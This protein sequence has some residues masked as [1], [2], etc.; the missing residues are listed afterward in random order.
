M[1]LKTAIK[2]YKGFHWGLDPDVVDVIETPGRWPDVLVALGELEA[3]IYR[4][5]KGREKAA[6]IH[7]FGGSL[8]IL[9]MDPET[10]H[11][12]IVGGD[13]RIEDRGIVG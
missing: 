5:T 10:D 6:F 4:T 8:P 9:A 1:D 12:Y 2:R 13:Y 7:D 3:V 11:L